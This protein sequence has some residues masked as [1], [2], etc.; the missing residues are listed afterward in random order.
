MGESGLLR[1]GSKLDGKLSTRPC[2]NIL[3]S[4]ADIVHYKAVNEQ[5]DH[6]MQYFLRKRFLPHS[7]GPVYANG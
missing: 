1:A 3:I 2:P 6:P 5:T 7:G 4:T